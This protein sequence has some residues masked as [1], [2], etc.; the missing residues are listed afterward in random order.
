MTQAL[1]IICAGGL[2]PTVN[3]IRGMRFNGPTR[4]KQFSQTVHQSATL[5][6]SVL[7]CGGNGVRDISGWPPYLARFDILALPPQQSTF[8][9]IMAARWKPRTHAV[10]G[11]RTAMLLA[12]EVPRNQSLGRYRGRCRQ[13][14]IMAAVT[15]TM[16]DARRRSLEAMEG[17]LAL[18]GISYPVKRWHQ[19]TA[20]IHTGVTTRRCRQSQRLWQRF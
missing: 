9:E 6:Q 14:E 16:C 19:D 1:S 15:L 12:S 3:S 8:K 10:S 2:Q 11:E 5:R 7:Y 18:I 4:A 20:T 13:I 17:I